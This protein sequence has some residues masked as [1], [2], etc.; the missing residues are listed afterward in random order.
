MLIV[1]SCR[2]CF[3]CPP[4]TL[5]SEAACLAAITRLYASVCL[6]TSCCC[7]AVSAS[8]CITYTLHVQV[9]KYE[10]YYGPGRRAPACLLTLVYASVSSARRLCINI[11][12]YAPP[13]IVLQHCSPLRWTLRYKHCAGSVLVNVQCQV[14]NR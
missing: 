14:L 4:G 13:R 9:N 1:G 2:G 7:R 5:A 12:H 8:H 6:L 3:R 11:H 10:R